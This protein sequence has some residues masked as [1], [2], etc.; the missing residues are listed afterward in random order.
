M[1]QFE[2]DKEFKFIQGEINKFKQEMK[3]HDDIIYEFESLK[4]QKLQRLEARKKD[5]AEYKKDLQTIC[6]ITEQTALKAY[7]EIGG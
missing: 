5:W 3:I 6:R 4:N 7:S 1:S 2:I